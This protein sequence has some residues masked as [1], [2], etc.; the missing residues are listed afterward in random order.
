MENEFSATQQKKNMRE[1]F[2]GKGPASSRNRHGIG[3]ISINIA[4]NE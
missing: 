4:I 2:S 1:P 3:V